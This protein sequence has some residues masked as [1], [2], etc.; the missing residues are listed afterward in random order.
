M[1]KGASRRSAWGLSTLNPFV[2]FA[3]FC[4]KSASP[5]CSSPRSFRPRVTSSPV[6][7]K[8]PERCNEVPAR[9]SDAWTR[10]HDVADR[11]NDATSG[12]IKAPRGCRDVPHRLSDVPGVRRKVAASGN[13]V[14]GRG[15]EA[16]S[17]WNE[18]KIN[19]TSDSKVV[20]KTTTC[21]VLRRICHNMRLFN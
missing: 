6:R 16:T 14:A 18:P 4:S 2:T 17:G 9:C 13:V 11:W 7:T 10:C 3:T 20:P 8:P 19:F 15:S 1:Q 12:W 21:S 5:S